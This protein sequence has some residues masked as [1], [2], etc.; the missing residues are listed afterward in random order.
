MFDWDKNKDIPAESINTYV[1]HY[2]K[3]NKHVTN[4]LQ[5]KEF[6]R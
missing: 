5:Q 3:A 2:S 6:E 1:T 4:Q